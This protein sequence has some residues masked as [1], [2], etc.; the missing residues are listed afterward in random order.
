VI[1]DESQGVTDLAVKL[2]M[3]AQMRLIGISEM[4]KEQSEQITTQLIRTVA[5][6]ELAMVEPMITALREND[7]VKAAKF[8]DLR[9]LNE[10]VGL[11]LGRAIGGEGARDSIEVPPAAAPAPTPPLA[12]MEVVI[13]TSL[14]G[15]GVAEDIARVLVAEAVANSPISD[16]LTVM[17]TITSTL[18]QSPPVV[19]PPKRK[20]VP[21]DELP[22]D[23][24]RL[25]VAKGKQE[26]VAAYDALLA[27]GVVRPPIL[28]FAA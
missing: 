20:K 18:K 15:M 11:V 17:Q 3:L 28:D 27:A 26:N 13:L 2:I 14:I 19:K 1:Y 10:H 24:L 25:I 21:V 23:D 16:P 12:S 9:S 8:D 6:E 22:D 5:K 4:R 7:T